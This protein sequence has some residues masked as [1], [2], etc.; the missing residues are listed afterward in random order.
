MGFLVYFVI[1]LLFQYSVY[2]E[3]TS[4]MNLEFVLH[5][6]LWWA[7][8][9]YLIA[10]SLFWPVAYLIIAG[11]VGYGVYWLFNRYVKKGTVG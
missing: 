2:G 9:L 8:G 10:V 7:F 1:G 3:P 6:V 5:V 11:L 4:I